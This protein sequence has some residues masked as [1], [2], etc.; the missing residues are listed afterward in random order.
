MTFNSSTSLKCS[1]QSPQETWLDKTAWAIKATKSLGRR[2]WHA[3]TFSK[4]KVRRQKPEC[5]VLKT[6]THTHTY[7]RVT[8]TDKPFSFFSSD[9]SSP[10]LLLLSS[11][12]F[13]FVESLEA[14]ALLWYYYCSVSLGQRELVGS[15]SLKH[16]HTNTHICKFSSEK[17]L[18][19]LFSL[20]A[21]TLLLLYIQL[22]TVD[23]VLCNKQIDSL[24]TALLMLAIV[25][26]QHL[27]Y[28]TAVVKLM[29]RNS[30]TSLTL[31]K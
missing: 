7:M 2:V 17:C 9:S 28:S 13:L 22:H 6:W 27:T 8:N 29:S 12:K 21:N 10:R 5:A 31:E 20:C 1:L 25:W 16:T 23:S 11:W 24:P 15:F 14:S 19:H 3:E 18:F 26:F 30:L 4:C